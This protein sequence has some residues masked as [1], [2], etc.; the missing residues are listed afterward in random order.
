MKVF[1]FLLLGSDPRVTLVWKVKTL[2][3]IMSFN[4]QFTC[5]PAVPPENILYHLEMNPL[6]CTAFTHLCA[7]FVF[8]MCRCLP[9]K[10][11][12]LIHFYLS[13]LKMSQDAESERLYTLFAW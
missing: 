10:N 5:L 9:C 2:L 12:N 8:E 1:F 3:N 13:S 11:K 7:K 4:A 6:T